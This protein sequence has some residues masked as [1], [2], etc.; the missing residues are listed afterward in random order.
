[1]SGSFAA[2]VFTIS[3][4]PTANGSF[5]Y[6]V[7]T[8]GGTCVPDVSLSGTI[9]VSP[10][11]TITLTSGSLYQAVCNGNPFTQN[12]YTITGTATSASI[13][14]GV[15]PLGLSGAYNAGIFSITG[16]QTQ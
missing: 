15:L 13:T 1:M 4:T 14:T 10:E 6:T 11:S 3:G 9:D 12:D 5:A 16:N 7:T 2:G 8:S